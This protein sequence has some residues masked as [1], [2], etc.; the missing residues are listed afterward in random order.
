MAEI[1]I[2]STAGFTD[3]RL[4]LSLADANAIEISNCAPPVG[5]TTCKKSNQQAM[6]SGHMPHP[7]PLLA[8]S[9]L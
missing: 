1:L 7:E 4:C 2:A 5:E 6:H 9:K 8:R 3:G